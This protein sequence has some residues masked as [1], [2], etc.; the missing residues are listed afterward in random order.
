MIF[1]WNS[2]LQN[3]EFLFDCEVINYWS[4]L[5]QKIHTFNMVLHTRSEDFLKPSTLR[6]QSLITERYIKI[7]K[8]EIRE[9]NLLSIDVLVIWFKA[10]LRKLWGRK[11]RHLS[12]KMGDGPFHMTY[13]IFLTHGF[14]HEWQ[15]HKPHEPQDRG[16]S[17]V[18][19]IFIPHVDFL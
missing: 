8:S 1:P 15:P 5:F 7:L 6:V 13:T 12:C 9:N 18:D 4:L 17:D 16:P 2:T 10:E 14:C 3:F 19:K 11:N